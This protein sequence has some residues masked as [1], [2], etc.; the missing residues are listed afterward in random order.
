M[1]N[2]VVSTEVELKKVKMTLVASRSS[3][4]ILSSRGTVIFTKRIL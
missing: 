2:T 3:I 4:K 1:E